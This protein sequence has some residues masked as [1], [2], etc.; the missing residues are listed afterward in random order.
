MNYEFE[1]F[2]SRLPSFV[3]EMQN[4]KKNCFTNTLYRVICSKAFLAEKIT[5]QFNNVVKQT[6][7]TCA[8]TSKRLDNIDCDM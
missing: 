5:F 6:N 2:S 4:M 1:S 8:A 3:K 7:I